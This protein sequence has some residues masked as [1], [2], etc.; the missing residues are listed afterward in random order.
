M[1]VGVERAEQ[2]VIELLAAAR[3]RI[4]R[5]EPA[6]ARERLE[7]GAVLVDLR[8][9]FERERDGIIPGSIHVPRSVL[10]WRVDDASGYSNPEVANRNLELILVCDEGYSSSLAA[11]GLL[12]LGFGHVADLVGGFQGW[13]AAGLEVAP[14]PPP[15]PGL[16]GMGGPDA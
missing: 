7:D 5:V 16:P 12:D 2:R 9:H 15:Q 10:E 4:R 11:A 6:E 1:L 3:A 8:S 13:R 14:A